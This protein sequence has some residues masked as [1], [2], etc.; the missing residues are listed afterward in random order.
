VP[1]QAASAKGAVAG[2]GNHR[3]YRAQE[4]GNRSAQRLEVADARMCELPGLRN[5]PAHAGRSLARQQWA[6]ACRR[7][8]R[9]SG[10]GA[11]RRHSPAARGAWRQSLPR[12]ATGPMGRSRGRSAMAIPGV[13]AGSTRRCCT[14]PASGDESPRPVLAAKKWAKE[15]GPVERAHRHRRDAGA[16]G[17]GQRQVGDIAE[18][19]IRLQLAEEAGVTIDQAVPVGMLGGD[20]RSAVASRSTL[21]G[22]VHHVAEVAARRQVGEVRP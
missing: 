5:Q 4:V 17:T 22:I 10:P 13:S 9:R 7:R 8:Q 18:H 16:R 19:Q 15:L 14:R 11:R 6:T 20:R 2:F 21:H 12:A 1:L 3:V